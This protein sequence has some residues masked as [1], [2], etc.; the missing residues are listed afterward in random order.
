MSFP[1]AFKRGK[2]ATEI[3]IYTDGGCWPNPGPGGWGIAVFRNDQLIHASC[4]GASYTTNNRMELIGAGAALAWIRDNPGMPRA[5]VVSDSKLILNTLGA[6]AA[7]WKRRGWTK[8]SDGEIKNLDLIQRVYPL[9]ELVRPRTELY[10]VKGHS[11]VMGN[12]L[13][14][15]LASLGQQMQARTDFTSADSVTDLYTNF[16]AKL[17]ARKEAA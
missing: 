13:A 6:W 12:E 8:S 15:H 1:S 3:S 10:W 14:D 5:A 11:G 9:Y 7:G 16:A 17:A 2:P 4:G